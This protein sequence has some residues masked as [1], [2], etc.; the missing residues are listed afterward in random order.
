MT[1]H[2]RN[3]RNAYLT[4][5]ECCWADQKMSIS[6]ENRDQVFVI[7]LHWWGVAKLV[8]EIRTSIAAETSRASAWFSGIKNRIG[9]Q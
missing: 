2:R 6:F 7:H 1:K 5:I 3:L 9:I 8:E 4:S